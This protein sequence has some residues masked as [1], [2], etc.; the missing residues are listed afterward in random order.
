MP[1]IRRRSLAVAVTLVAVSLALVGCSASSA[2]SA[3]ASAGTPTSGGSITVGGFVAGGLDPGVPTFSLQSAGFVA[4]IFGSLFTEPTKTGGKYLPNLASGYKY[5]SDQLTL[6]VSLRPGL[7][8]SDGTPLNAAAAA[9][10]LNRYVTNGTR[11]KTFFFNVTSIKASGD[12][13]VVIT[14][15]APNSL[16]L[17]AMA[18]SSTGYMVSPTALQKMGADAFNNAPVGAGPFE[19]VS[20]NNGQQLVLKKNPNYYDAKHVYLDGLTYLNTGADP[21]S[22]L[23]S[24][25]SGSIQS[26][27]WP[28]TYTSPAVLS[29]AKKSGFSLVEGPNLRALFLPINTYQAPFNNLKARQAISYCIDRESIAK[30]VTQGYATPAFVLSGSQS[31]A[32][33]GWQEGKKLNPLQYSVSKG[34][35]LVKSLGGLSFTITTSINSPVLTALQQ[36]W[37][38][39]GID[40]KIDLTPA[41]LAD[42]QAGN[43]QMSFT[44]NV[45][46]STNPAASTNYLDPT[47]PNNKFGWADPSISNLVTQAKATTNLADSTKLWHTIWTDLTKQGFVV[48]IVSAGDYVA[49]SPKLKGVQNLHNYGDYTHAYL[50]K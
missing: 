22:A 11:E 28:G 13:D 20:D 49:S 8:F 34:K 1:S 24:L 41:Y 17:D 29:G 5:S 38:A 44:I 40:A 2:P 33:S 4:P 36:E 16:L 37:K 30:N 45:N 35:A 26:V 18:T 42:V 19:V 21:Q 6:T 48:P 3:S 7:K 31:T 27:D 23:V 46:A 15:S 10:N 47:T 9:W 12:T 14:F 43:Y 50:T 25:Q 39:C 32:L